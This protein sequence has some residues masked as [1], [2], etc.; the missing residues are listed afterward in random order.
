MDIPG[1]IEI[2]AAAVADKSRD[3][4]IDRR[5]KGILISEVIKDGFIYEHVN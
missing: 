1:R 4:Q 5:D 2:E 3:I